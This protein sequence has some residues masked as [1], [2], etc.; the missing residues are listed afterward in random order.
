MIINGL[1]IIMTKIMKQDID[2]A[3]VERFNQLKPLII[4]QNEELRSMVN[5]EVDQ[6]ND[7]YNAAQAGKEVSDCPHYDFDT[8]N[9]KI[10]FAWCSFAKLNAEIT[11]LQSELAAER[12]KH[13]WISVEE[14]LPEQDSVVIVKN[15]GTVCIGWLEDGMW[16]GFPRKLNGI[17]DWMPLPQPPVAK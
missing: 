11:R 2:K 9:W 5:M 13:R 8:D 3:I 12:E 14:Q 4:K 1:N 10:G 7:G 6:F 16:W 17:T 15:S